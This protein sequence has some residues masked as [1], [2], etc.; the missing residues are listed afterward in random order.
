[1][2]WGGITLL[3][4]I[5]SVDLWQ[6]RLGMLMRKIESAAVQA[7]RLFNTL[8]QRRETPMPLAR[9]SFP[10]MVRHG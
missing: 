6:G 1:M 10:L 9:N 5:A 3:A 4:I 8:A 7:D 2:P